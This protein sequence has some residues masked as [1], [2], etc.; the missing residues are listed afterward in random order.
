M[1]A[2]WKEIRGF[3]FG[4]ALALV[5]ASP[6]SG[7]EAEGVRVTEQGVLV[8][9]QDADLRFVL[10]ALAEAGNLNVIYAEL[11]ER[12]VTL[13]MRSPVA[14]ENIPAL[15]RSLAQSNGLVVTEEA[16][17][18]RLEVAGSEVAQGGDD[19]EGPE[20][21]PRLFVH[22]LKHARAA[23]MA[24]TLQAIFGGHAS[25]QTLNVSRR[26]LS[27][28]L[29]G[30]RIPPGIPDS[31]PKAQVEVGVARASLPGQLHGEIQIVP[32]EATNALLVRALPSDWIVMQGAIEQLD[33]RPLQVMIEVLIAEVH[34]TQKSSLS[35][36]GTVAD[37]TGNPQGSAELKGNTS[38]DLVLEL[39]RSG[40]VNVNLALSA[41]AARGE[42]T[43]LSRPV[44]LAQNNQEARILIGSER[45]FVQVFRSLPTDGASRDQI[46]QYREVGTKLTIVPTINDDGYVNLQVV[47]EVSNATAET[48]FDAPVISTREASTHLFVRSGQTA[49]IGGLIDHLRERSKSGIPLLIDIPLI[50]GL[51]GTTSKSAGE[52]ELF[53]FLTPHIVAT[54]EDTDRVRE[55]IVEATPLLEKA[56]PSGPVPI[57]TPAGTAAAGGEQK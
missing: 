16:G 57:I 18:L 10:A 41:L 21:E 53:L 28:E 30:Q 52:S 47:Q 38:G 4:L 15:L 40:G 22:R 25:V 45:P 39:L 33:L 49:V 44:I 23:R 51:F 12:R 27:E 11:P 7:Q 55:S 3:A 31:M 48:Q 19:G 42:V 6:A 36:S 54:D 56:L 13:R 29:R 14:P 46:V 20:E 32:D 9:F 26:P 24:A 35:V 50:G 8:D 34:R 2:F 43:I 5:S 17:F 37:V 1:V